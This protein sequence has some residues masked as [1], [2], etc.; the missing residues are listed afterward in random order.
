M[1]AIIDVNYVC[2]QRVLNMIVIIDVNYV[3][4]H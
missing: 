4:N 1:I 3:C 2:N